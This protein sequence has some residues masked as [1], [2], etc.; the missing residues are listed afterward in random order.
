[1]GQGRGIVED[2]FKKEFSPVLATV[3]EAPNLSDRNSSTSSVDFINPDD[4]RLNFVSD[5]SS[6]SSSQD[7]PFLQQCL[8]G[9]ISEHLIF[10]VLQEAQAT[11]TLDLFARCR[12]F[13]MS[14]DKTPVEFVS[15]NFVIVNCQ[16]RM[17]MYAFAAGKHWGFKIRIVAFSPPE[18]SR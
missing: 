14:S 3:S 7:L 12:A 6:L 18:P 5:S 11:E 13:R 17:K 1:M 2:P 9:L 4:S 16:C 10:A 15:S 8:Q